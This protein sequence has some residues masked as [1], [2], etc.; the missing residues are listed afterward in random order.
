MAGFCH[1]CSI[2]PGPFIPVNTPLSLQQAP[3]TLLLV[4]KGFIAMHDVYYLF[5]H[6]KGNVYP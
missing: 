4:R 6:G 5:C 3:V 1:F 2:R